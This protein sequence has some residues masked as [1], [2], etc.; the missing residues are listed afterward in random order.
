QLSDEHMHFVT[1][2][3]LA[4][5]A[6]EIE[7]SREGVFPLG[8]LLGERCQC[9]RTG[10]RYAVAHGFTPLDGAP[11]EAMRDFARQLR[12]TLAAHDP[13]VHGEIV[14][15][16]GRA[17]EVGP[18]MHPQQ[19]RIHAR[20]FKGAWMSALLVQPSLLTPI[21][22]LYLYS[23]KAQRSYQTAFHEILLDAGRRGRK[24]ALDWF[25][26]VTGGETVPPMGAVEQ[27]ALRRQ[28]L[29][30]AEWKEPGALE[31]A[32]DQLRAWMSR[33]ARGA[34]TGRRA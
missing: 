24:T 13:R 6:S 31:Q 11:A 25:N 29:G 33:P 14:G 19:E 2:P 22:G 34:R 17:G 21:G 20:L 18:R 8:L 4:V 12:A 23:H 16:Y 28:P 3:L 26:Y 27:A 10:V 15:W 9:T 1:Q 32:L 5:L 7:A 30:F